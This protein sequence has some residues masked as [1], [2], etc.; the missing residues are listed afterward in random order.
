MNRLFLGI[1]CSIL[2]VMPVMGQTVPPPTAR[3]GNFTVRGA[4]SQE[5]TSSG[6]VGAHPSLPLNS[7]VKITNPEN[8][9]EIEITIIGR[10]QPSLS[11]IID[12]SP[13][14]IRALDMTAGGQ[15]ILTVPAPPPIAW[16]R[17][18][19][20]IVDMSREEPPKTFSG[21]Q[22]IVQIAPA[23]NAPAGGSSNNME[24]LL[25]AFL[26]AQGAN[27]Q[28][29]GQTSVTSEAVITAPSSGSS[30][31][32]EFLAWLMAMSLD[33]RSAREARYAREAREAREAQEAREAREAREVREAREAREV[34][35]IREAREAREA[36]AARQISSQPA[37]NNDTNRQSVLS[38]LRDSNTPPGFR[39]SAN[40]STRQQDTI[41]TE[42]Q[43]SSVNNQP[44]VQLI[45][46]LPDANSGKVY[47]LQIGAYSTPETAARA[48][49][50]LLSAGFNVELELSNP[51]YRVVVTGINAR[52]VQPVSVR[53]G[54]FGFNQIWVRD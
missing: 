29:A 36:A 21:T 30:K 42:A 35:E 8:N 15:V 6:L 23:Q 53:L 26:V 19:E 18:S 48:V 32:S 39:I 4:A 5:M 7:K 28:D 3:L 13:A 20:L 2:I 40:Q 16:A 43:K 37:A 51:V 54:S 9:R 11:R 45:P 22:E 33:T 27:R 12:L 52:D 44:P 25:Q 1:L 50:L 38:N 24:A 46:G 10:I 41:Q 17:Q 34:R 47:R 31:S 14:A 49:E